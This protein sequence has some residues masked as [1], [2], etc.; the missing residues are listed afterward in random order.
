[1]TSPET[2]DDIEDDDL[3]DRPVDTGPRKRTSRLWPALALIAIVIPTVATV[4][5]AVT[6]SS[7]MAAVPVGHMVYMEAD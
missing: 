1:M 7:G 6:S 2:D 4:I 5:G 3:A